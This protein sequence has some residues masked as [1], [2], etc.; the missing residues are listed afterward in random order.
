MKKRKM[1]SYISSPMLLG[2]V[3]FFLAGPLYAQTHPFP[4]KSLPTAVRVDDLESRLSLDQ[5]IGLLN[6]V[7]PAIPALG[8]HSYV[9]WN[10]GLHGVARAGEATVFPQ[11]IGMAASFDDSLLYRVADAISTEARAKYNLFQAHG[12]RSFFM[13]LSFW[14]PNINIFRDPRWGRGQETYGEDPFL[15]ATMGTAFVHGMQGNDPTQLKTAACAKHYAV[16][17]GPEAERHSF[18]AI[19][20]EKDLRETYLYAF[21]KLTDAGVASVMC[22]YNRVNGE[23]C[24]TSH[25]LLKNI[26]L[27]EW[28][29]KGQVVT[30]CGALDDITDGH[31]LL[32]SRAEVAAAA[33]KAGVNLECGGVFAA[34]I[35]SAIGQ[36][37][38]TVSDIDA[39]LKP[40]L[41]TALKL[42]M[43][44]PA[45]QSPYTIYG[46][47]SIDNGYHRTLSAQM[48]AES[49]VLLK[50]DGILPL[51]PQKLASLYVTGPLAASADVLSGNYHGMSGHLVT[52]AEGLTKAA[53]PAC[54]VSYDPG[55]ND[56]DSVHFA[57]LMIAGLSDVSIVVIGLTPQLEGEEGDAFAS[58]VDGDK[59]TLSVPASELRY[60]QEVRKAARKVIVV[61]TAGSAVDM[62]AITPYADA[63]I[64]AWYPGEE[65]GMA[66]ADLVFG[67][68][69][70]SGRLPVTFYNRLS[71]LPTYDNYAMQGRTYRYFQGKAQ[72]PFGYG[73]S[74]TSF[75][76]SWQTLPHPRYSGKDTISFSVGVRN[77]GQMDGDEVVQAYIVYPGLVRMPVKEL[78][79]FKRVSIAKGAVRTVTLSIPV[80][81][82]E[83]WDSAGHGWKLY[84]G[85]YS[86]GIGQDADHMVLQQG[87]TIK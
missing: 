54:A 80:S 40:T 53:G 4:D 44:E 22:A 43:Y 48:A 37:L 42:G 85:S 13:G 15:T 55:C 11:S 47:D 77:A 46:A 30:D 71:D 5:K 84:P 83:K 81:E 68:V 73:L 27:D 38:L 8:I 17:S 35:D 36:G 6:F 76:Y 86:I 29:Y 31:H 60:L 28:Q 79:A 56:R 25:A 52:F 9:W 70:P 74:Y 23:A 75:D 10:E 33:I 32:K 72:Y 61:V 24:C 69:S 2:G 49:M 59:K 87:F 34:D 39:A 65:G 21:K 12:R 78:K 66:L 58:D 51:N 67:R 41:K 50:N 16:H 82:L 62:A 3:A 63:V 45:S 64:L 14:S 7:S 18:N 20:D 19:V 1:K 26:L 57:S